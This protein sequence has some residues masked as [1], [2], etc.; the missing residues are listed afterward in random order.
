MVNFIHHYRSKGANSGRAK[1]G[2]LGTLG[3]QF[4]IIAPGATG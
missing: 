3:G 1:T 4:E 2:A